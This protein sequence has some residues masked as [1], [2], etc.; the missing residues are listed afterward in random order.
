M[1]QKDS[2][3]FVT[4]ASKGLGNA[5]TRE[6]LSRGYKVVATARKTDPLRE[7]ADN[8]NILILPM[9]ITDPQQIEETV[10]KVVDYFGRIDVL[11]NNAGNGFFGYYEEMTMEQIRQHLETNFFGP[12]NVTRAVLP[13]MRRQK[14][15][16]IV[17]T[18]S[19]SGI[20]ST[21]G[22]SMY[23]AGKF[24][25]E[26]WMEGLNFEV[27]RFGIKCMILEPGAFRT[28][29][30]DHNTFTL[31]GKQEETH[32]A[33]YDDCRPD[34]HAKFLGVDGTQDGNPVKYAK[35]AVD[36]LESDYPPFRLVISKSA[37]PTVITYYDRRMEEL[38]KW[39]DVSVDT[40]FDTEEERNVEYKGV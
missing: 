17:T 18:G 25:I 1:I 15:G 35:H 29:I 37:Y 23:S 12:M 16:Y 4:G 22:G 8:E 40:E 20:R 28:S 2:V 33:D 5:V 30:Y 19:T 13:V 6:L 32:I 31:G 38:K 27:G 14:S 24:A 11:W 10:Q 3:F 39:E 21:E 36:A 26:G 9:D 7:F 34:L